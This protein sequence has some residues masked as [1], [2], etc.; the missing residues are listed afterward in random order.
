MFIMH[1]NN[2]L[3]FSYYAMLLQ[4]LSRRMTLL[5]SNYAPFMRQMES[6]EY[7]AYYTQ[8]YTLV[9]SGSLSQ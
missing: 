4:M 7:A 5:C 3:E 2:M 6:K 9:C 1:W 8:A